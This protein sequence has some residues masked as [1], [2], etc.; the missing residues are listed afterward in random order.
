LIKYP[1]ERTEFELQSELYQF[2]L[3]SGYDVRGEI[4]DKQPGIRGARFD[5]VVYKNKQAVAILEIK[6]HVNK[7]YGTKIST[8]YGKYMHYGLPIYVISGQKQINEFKSMVISK[9]GAFWI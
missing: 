1:K 4:K 9:L 3:G 7:K 5:I 6:D 2:L 8:V